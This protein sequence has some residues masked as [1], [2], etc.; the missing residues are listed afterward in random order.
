MRFLLA[1]ARKDLRRRARDPI[2]LLLWV[3]IPATIALLLGVI[4]GGDGGPPTADVLVTDRDS[5]VVSRLLLGAA[6]SGGSP[7]AVE[8]V[9]EEAGRRRMEDGDASA[10]VVV[11]DGFGRALLAP[12]AAGDA[13]RTVTVVTNPAQGVLPQ[14][15]VEMMRSLAD[16]SFYGRELLGG[17]LATAVA[18][19][20]RPSEAEVADLATGISERL[21]R[22]DGLL[23][24]PVLRLSVTTRGRPASGGFGRLLL[25]GIVFMSLLLV[26]EGV[27]G[28]LWEERKEGT[29]SRWRVAPH[30]V[31]AVLAGKLLAGAVLSLGVAAVGFGAGAVLLDVS[32]PHLPAAVAWAAAAVVCLV[33][34][35]YLLQMAA[36]SRRGGNLLS[37]M[38]LFPLLMLGG[39][40]FP[41][42]AMP[43]W[44]ATT[45]TWLP[46]GRA[47]L[48]LR[49]LLAGSPEPAEIAATGGVLLLFGAA[50]FAA[51]AALIPRR[52]ATAGGE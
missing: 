13:A 49:D 36:S 26:G 41:F 40:F 24:P 28:D 9:S 18:A 14:V 37:N 12:R 27:A 33:P 3:G 20:G 32:L 42:E 46:N 7:V 16:L 51:T 8:R 23:F 43:G 48:V 10:L 50:T 6:G 47:V 22:S 34:F 5:S 11:P 1:T 38:V 15:P 21:R 44:M 4:A 45:G 29:L 35:F 2:S 52:F 19:G 39:S 25:P 17:A 30:S 31:S